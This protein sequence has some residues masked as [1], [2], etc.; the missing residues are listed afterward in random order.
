MIQA[1]DYQRS[2]WNGDFGVV[3]QAVWQG[4]PM[5]CV[6]F[7]QGDLLRIFPLL[8]LPV[9]RAFAFSV[10][11]SQ[12]SEFGEVTL[13]LPE[14]PS[15]LLTRELVYTAITRGRSCVRVA[16]TPAILQAGLSTTV[17][18]RMNLSRW[19]FGESPGPVM[20]KPVSGT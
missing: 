9:A 3:L 2:L 10:H 5:P 20:D 8:G 11:K 13:V 4:D 7:L 6:A 19:L 1:N 18:R 12:G 17:E 14:V 15:L 16:G